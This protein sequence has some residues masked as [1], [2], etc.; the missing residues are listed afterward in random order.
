MSNFYRISVIVVCVAIAVGFLAVSVLAQTQQ[1]SIYLNNSVILIDKSAPGEQRYKMWYSGYHDSAG[2][3]RIGYATSSDGIVWTK[4]NQ[5]DHDNSG[6]VLDVGP[7]GAWDDL[8]VSRSRYRRLS[9]VWRADAIYAT[10]IKGYQ[11]VKEIL[12]PVSRS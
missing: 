11:D 7:K 6:Y 10:R 12:I 1:T 2:G 5:D 4:H 3:A 9:R 8:R